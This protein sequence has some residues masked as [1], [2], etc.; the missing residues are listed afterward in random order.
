MISSAR[1]SLPQQLDIVP[2]A[3]MSSIL[4]QTDRDFVELERV[5][6]E[7]LADADEAEA[8]AAAEGVDPTSS[9]WTMV[10]L[11]RFLGGLR[12]EAERDAAA[13]VQ[14]AQQRARVRVEEA[15]EEAERRRLGYDPDPLVPPIRLTPPVADPPSA[16]P[17][18]ATPLASTPLAATPLAATAASTPVVTPPFAAEAPP[19]PVADGRADETRP[20]QVLAIDGSTFAPPATAR[21][22]EP[23]QAAHHAGA[24][25]ADL[26]AVGGAVLVA[27][28][29]APV[30][31]APPA[32]VVPTSA[33]RAQVLPAPAAQVAPVAE[34]SFVDDSF[35]V[36]SPLE[37]TTT[38]LAPAASTAVVVPPA[39][40][41]GEGEAGTHAPPKQGR[42]VRHKEE[43][44]AKQVQPVPPKP[45]KA[46]LLKRLPVSAILEVLAVL[47]ILVFILLRLS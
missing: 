15:R 34:P 24:A 38:A 37:S 3:E 36:G 6:G 29:D 17:P 39:P 45:A 32:P 20:R 25:A 2:A 8:L 1:P 21:T 47:L 22:P 40:A 28:D 12:E 11:Q 7:T 13:T 10:R 16:V 9:T 4:E 44:A 14:V 18:V 27:S 43:K 35:W 19:A 26:A 46:G 30:V 41:V 23:G 5:H 31:T 42:R 33:E